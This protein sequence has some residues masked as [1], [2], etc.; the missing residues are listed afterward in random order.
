MAVALPDAFG[1]RALWFAVTYVLVRAIGLVLQAWVASEDP[2]Q[3]VAVRTWIIVSLGGL[4]AVLAGGFLGGTLQFWLWGVAILLD[5]IAAMIGGQAEGWNL[6]PEHF[7]ERHALFVII[8][9]G[10]TLIVAAGRVTGASWSNDLLTVALLA[11]AITCGLWWSYFPRAKPALEQALDSV[12]GTEQ[13]RMARDVY[14]LLHFPMLCGVVAYAF[15]IEEIVA[16]PG[17]VLDLG[18]RLA[19]AAGLLLFVGVMAIAISRA[20]R[21]LLLPRVFLTISTAVI[22][23]GASGIAGQFTLAI[24]FTGILAITII[25]QSA[26]PLVHTH[27]QE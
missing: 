16:H 7:A 10:E 9:L 6:H 25:E 12:G 2:T 22:V 11:V 4:V 24:A 3:K 17:E 14:S 18:T 20:T 21:H 13:S 8:A 15:V 19:L 5:V 26:G 27:P 1:E 23:V